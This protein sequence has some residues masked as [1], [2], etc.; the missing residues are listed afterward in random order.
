MGVDGGAVLENAANQGDARLVSQLNGIGGWC[1]AGGDDRETGADG[2]EDD[3][4]ADTPGETEQQPVA[5]IGLLQCP[6]DDLVNRVVPAEIVGDP[7]DLMPVGYRGEVE[8][9]GVVDLA[10]T[11]KDGVADGE[12]ARAREAEIGGLIGIVI[13]V[14][15]T[16][17]RLG[18]RDDDTSVEPG[19]QQTLPGSSRDAGSVDHQRDPIAVG[20]LL[21][22][23]CGVLEET[24]REGPTEGEFFGARRGPQEVGDRPAIDFD[25]QRLFLRKFVERGTEIE[26]PDRLRGER[27]I[28]QSPAAVDP[29]RSLWSR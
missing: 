14:L 28:A 7:A 25:R 22:H 1:G 20:G 19:D 9:A 26:D 24:V 13:A 6:A 18:G 29:A 3:A 27:I 23:T 4:G 5:W 2:F 8:T 15:I 10:K 16:G 17:W 11:P 12:K 21:A